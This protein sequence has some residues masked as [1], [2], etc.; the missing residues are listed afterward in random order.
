MQ[1]KTYLRVGKELIDYE[2]M[3]YPQ[4]EDYFTKHTISK[5]VWENLQKEA[6]TNVI[7]FIKNDYTEEERNNMTNEQICKAIEDYYKARNYTID[8]DRFLAHQINILRGK[9]PFGYTIED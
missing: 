8:S 9:V 1:F 6:R 7:E 5:Y 2:N 3:L 4:Y